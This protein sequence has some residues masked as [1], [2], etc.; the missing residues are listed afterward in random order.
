MTH[1]ELKELIKIEGIGEE[2]KKIISIKENKT[3][4][5]EGGKT[6]KKANTNQP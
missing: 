1:P 6:R 5:F 4:D 3:I 2:L